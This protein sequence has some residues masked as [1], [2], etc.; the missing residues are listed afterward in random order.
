MQDNTRSHSRWLLV[1][2]WAL[3]VGGCAPRAAVHVPVEWRYPPEKPRQASTP[4][5]SQQPI[6]APDAPI[7]ERDVSGAEGAAAG[8]S[9]EPA[10][11]QRLASTGFVEQGDAHMAQGNADE[12]IAFYE[13]AVQVDAYNG[14]AFFGL[15]KAW[16]RKG[17]LA[18]SLEFARKAEIL[19][20]NRTS[21][22]KDVYLF[23]AD[24]HQALND[25][26]KARWYRDRAARL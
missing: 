15:A 24:L 9:Q 7:Q 12:A 20:Q 3:L 25:P 16:R 13:Q 14:D 4:S 17:Q 26:E 18:R 19:F 11:P 1:V 5:Q 6:L 10:T 21:K 23:Q 22:L 2:A 8:A